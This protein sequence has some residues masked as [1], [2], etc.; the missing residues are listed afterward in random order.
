VT[1]TDIQSFFTAKR[2]ILNNDK[3]IESLVTGFPSRILL[4]NNIL[5]FK[6]NNNL[7][8]TFLHIDKIK[9]S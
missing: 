1:T 7:T 8:R 5:L 6:I 4:R 2:E 9:I 3:I